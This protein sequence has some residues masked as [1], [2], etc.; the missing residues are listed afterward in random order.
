MTAETI[1]SV[2]LLFVA[3]DGFAVRSAWFAH[4]ALPRTTYAGLVFLGTAG[5]SAW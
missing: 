1:A 3:L 4:S 2:G 5:V